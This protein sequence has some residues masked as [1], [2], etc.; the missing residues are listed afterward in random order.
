MK[1]WLSLRVSLLFKKDIRMKGGLAKNC[2]LNF[3]YK[4]KNC[5]EAHF[6]QGYGTPFTKKLSAGEVL[7]K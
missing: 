5:N 3:I 2:A 7:A 6:V 1:W 4:L